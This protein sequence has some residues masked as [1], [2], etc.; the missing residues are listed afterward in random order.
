M[1][2]KWTAIQKKNDS[3]VSRKDKKGCVLQDNYL[4]FGGSNNSIEI[5]NFHTNA[6]S[7]NDNRK[8]HQQTSED[9]ISLKTSHSGLYYEHEYWETTLPMNQIFGHTITTVEWNK[10]ILV[11][12]TYDWQTTVLTRIRDRNPHTPR[13]KNF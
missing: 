4:L 6:F 11:G 10:A 3:I 12:G 2:D 13:A 9:Q 1:D 5:L 8:E 7:V